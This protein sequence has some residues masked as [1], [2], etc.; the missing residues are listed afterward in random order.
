MSI[1]EKTSTAGTTRQGIDILKPLRN[2]LEK[3]IAKGRDFVPSSD[4]ALSIE[5]PLD[6]YPSVELD[7]ET[8]LRYLHRD[9]IFIE[10]QPEGY[11]IVCHEGHPLGFV[12][13]IGRRWNNLHPLERRIRI[14]L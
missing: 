8:S 12:K 9:G 13:N 1:L 7:K 5:P 3:G 6:K 14:D 10:G 4:W 2:G 11:L